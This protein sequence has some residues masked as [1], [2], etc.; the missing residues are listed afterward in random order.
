[1][2]KLVIKKIAF[3][4]IMTLLCFPFCYQ[5]R[6]G[7]ITKKLRGY[8]EPPKKVELNAKSFLDGSWQQYAE[9]YAKDKLK[10][11]HFLIRLNNQ[12]KYS[13]FQELNVNGVKKGQNDF[14]F[15]YRYIEAY[16]GLNFLGEVRI[17][18]HVAKFARLRDSLA[19]RDIEMLYVIASGKA[20][21]MPD[22][23]P[24]KYLSIEK[25][26][27]NYESYLHFFD[28]YKIPHLDFNQYLL[29]MKDTSAYPLYTRGNI[30]WSFYGLSYVVDS[31]IA[32]METQLD[33]DLPDYT[34]ADVSL[35]YEP[36]YYTEGGIFKSL[37]LLWTEI[38]DTF[39]YRDPIM[40]DSLNVNKYYPRIWT[41]GDSFYGTLC[42]YEV[43]QRFFDPNSIFFYYNHSLVGTIY[44]Y[45][46]MPGTLKDFI[47]QI[48]EQDMIMFFTTDAGL[49]GCSWGAVDV[50]LDYFDHP[51]KDAGPDNQ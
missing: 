15:E 22:H 31:L 36:K 25:H 1:M 38:Q 34:R 39:A 50:M 27:N 18:E 17:E 19:A 33:R 44:D 8:F 16:L 9:A 13:L 2:S 43:P 30:H 14:Y 6:E 24:D 45:N 49:P 40:L 12:L 32:Q 7:T 21:Y 48:E 35:A 20:N 11:R 23:L 3:I 41:I 47:S 26:P 42:T 4:F 29:D 28:Q 37:N 10:T 46:Y 51:P 5:F